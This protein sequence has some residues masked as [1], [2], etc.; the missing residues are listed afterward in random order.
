VK[1]PKLSCPF[2]LEGT[3]DKV[4]F[5]K[6][7]LNFKS[8]LLLFGISHDV[9]TCKLRKEYEKLCPLSESP[10][11][12]H[13]ADDVLQIPDIAGSSAFSAEGVMGSGDCFSIVEFDVSE[14]LLL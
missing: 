3:A 13:L 6:K 4:D 8:Q 10:K 12:K 5:V 2:V 7:N 1:K 9:E 11:S 14:A